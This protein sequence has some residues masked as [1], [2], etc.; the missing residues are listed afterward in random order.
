[1]D[2]VDREL[3]RA[4]PDTDNEFCWYQLLRTLSNIRR[5]EYPEALVHAQAAVERQSACPGLDPDLESALVLEMGSLDPQFGEAL[6]E[7]L[8]PFLPQYPNLSAALA[9]RLVGSGKFVAAD[10]LLSSVAQRSP[11]LA[12]M[13]AELAL[14]LGDY[15]AA[16]SRAYDAW[17]QGLSSPHWGLWYDQFRQRVDERE[18]AGRSRL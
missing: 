11:D 14:R 6:V 18:K 17:M 7:R 9:A 16:S 3:P 12:A 10:R 4:V 2:R 1:L 15:R 13:W 5:G 8:L